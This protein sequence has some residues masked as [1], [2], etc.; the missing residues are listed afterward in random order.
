MAYTFLELQE[1]VR[2]FI[3]VEGQDSILLVK[4]LINIALYEVARSNKWPE[5]LQT[6]IA[7]NLTGAS[8]GVSIA[9]NVG[10]LDIERARYI[11]LG[12]EWSLAE[13]TKMVPPAGITGKP[14]A[15]ALI[16]GPTTQPY[17]I[18][19][20]PY[21]AIDLGDGDQ[22]LVDLWIAPPLLVAD[23]DT[24]QSNQWD[25]AIIRKA[26]SLFL[27]HQNKIPA[28]NVILGQMQA[29]QQQQQQQQQSS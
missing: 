22:C 20:D 15:Y 18:Q 8:T 26:E 24:P 1:R 19:L 7:L 21:S 5:L 6:N 23:G 3:K 11:S 9:L 25:T 27:I 13:R 14:R 29:V 4:D 16:K 28:A 12:V 2:R 10:T 17:G